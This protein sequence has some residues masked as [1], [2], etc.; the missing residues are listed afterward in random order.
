MCM[1]PVGEGAIRV[2]TGLSAGEGADIGFPAGNSDLS[3][4]RGFAPG[5]DGAGGLSTRFGRLPSLGRIVSGIGAEI[6]AQ[7]DRAFLWTPVAY[8][9]GAAAYLGLKAEP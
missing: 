5:P 4:A 3:G 9:A 1:A 6:S 8:G 2:T 7:A